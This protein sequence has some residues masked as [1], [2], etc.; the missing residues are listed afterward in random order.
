MIKRLM[1][2]IIGLFLAPSMV[3]ATLSTDLT[4]YYSLE[5]TGFNYV[6]SHGSVDFTSGTAPT[7]ITGKIDF[8]QDFQSDSIETSGTNWGTPKTY[9]FWVDPDVINNGYYISGS[10]G[11][12]VQIYNDGSS[13]LNYYDGSG[14][15]I[16]T[17]AN[18]LSTSGGWQHV[19]IVLDGGN[20]K[21]YI[22]GSAVALSANSIST[23]PAMSGDLYMGSYK[24]GGIN[25]DA[26]LDE[27]GVWDR[28]LSSSEVSDLY[29]GGAGLSYNDIVPYNVTNINNNVDRYYKAEASSGNLVDATGN[30]NGVA[31][32][33]TYQVTGKI[34]YAVEFDGSNADSVVIG[35]GSFAP[36]SNAD[37][38][39]N[40]QWVYADA[41]GSYRNLWRSQS[42]GMSF[43]FQQ[44]SNDDWRFVWYNGGPKFDAIGGSVNTG[45]WDFICGVN[46]G[47]GTARLYQ[48]GVQVATSAI[49][50]NSV[51]SYSHDITLGI[52]PSANNEKFD[53]K[54]DEISFFKGY[55]LTQADIN[56]LYAL[57]SPGSNQQYIFSN[58][59]PNT[60]PTITAIADQQTN[61]DEPIPIVP[62]AFTIGDAE[63]PISSLTLSYTSSDTALINSTGS[64][65]F[66]VNTTTGVV[67]MLDIT[68]NANAFGTSTI[69]VT[70]T[71]T[72]SATN[73]TSFLLT[74]F[75]V[76]DAPTITPIA[77]QTMIQGNTLVIDFNVTDVDNPY[78]DLTYTT[79]SLSSDFV[80]SFSSYDGTNQTLSLTVSPTAFGEQFV[81]ITVEDLQPARASSTFY[82]RVNCNTT[83]SYYSPMNVT[84]QIS[85]GTTEPVVCLDQTFTYDVA[86]DILNYT[87]DDFGSTM[88]DIELYVYDTTGNNLNLINQTTVSTDSGTQLFDYNIIYPNADLKIIA[89]LTDSTRS[90]FV[91]GSP[92]RILE[93]NINQQGQLGSLF[94]DADG[95][96][97]G[98]LILLLFITIGIAS[99]SATLTLIFSILG[100]F[101][102]SKFVL[103]IP[104]EFIWI[105]GALVVIL[106]W[107]IAKLRT[108]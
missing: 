16:R 5:E 8:G 43:N 97:Y 98:V 53:G 42:G 41:T 60:N 18:A 87:W 25:L 37:A 72:N 9:A 4:N 88:T 13:R 108:D 63:D 48:N 99:Q 86:T 15:Q 35:S 52:N 80:G 78:T 17:N 89:E 3:F 92:A 46:D 85:Q 62:S 61:E 27:F 93:A 14:N 56:F 67:D 12:P 30:Y 81:N 106:L 66:N 107:L 65:T 69:D 100:L 55:A 47:S 2:V 45:Q 91:G 29:N 22:D 96:I 24:N 64:I 49:S 51:S 76:N 36:L 1:I 54:L 6:D 75:A 32:G 73:T 105:T 58:A 39:S 90:P 102:A 31:S 33:I 7:R 68:P 38:F 103:K 95:I 71:D 84:T 70:V 94:S 20:S 50:S 19:A 44:T 101:I 57:G 21:I 79:N 23:L 77:N 28:P 10:A 40:C 104:S 82:V 74:V 11:T 83:T 34:D 59:A 26:G